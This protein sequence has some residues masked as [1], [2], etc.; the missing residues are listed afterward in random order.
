MKIKDNWQVIMIA[1]L[2]ILGV[3]LYYNGKLAIANKEIELTKMP[4]NYVLVKMDPNSS[5][6]YTTIL[7][8]TINT[9]YEHIGE[10]KAQNNWLEQNL[11]KCLKILEAEKGLEPIPLGN[12]QSRPQ[13]ESEPWFEPYKEPN[14]LPF[15]GGTDV[16]VMIGSMGLTSAST[17][18]FLDGSTKKIENFE[19]RL[20][21]LAPN[22]P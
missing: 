14:I 10:L 11:D 21:R 3:V 7:L 13:E 5:R 16:Q 17:N 9:M 19:E 6:T 22:Q 4:P 8:P 18:L 2:L 20:K 12:Y 1:L 15:L